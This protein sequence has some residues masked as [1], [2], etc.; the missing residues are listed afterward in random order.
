MNSVSQANANGLH[1]R[2]A[3]SNNSS[4]SSSS[5]LYVNSGKIQ[6]V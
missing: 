1:N 6:K 3:L 2:A 5:E 4:A